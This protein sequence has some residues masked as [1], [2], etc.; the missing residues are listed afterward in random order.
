ME[1]NKALIPPTG[2][3]EV[4]EKKK[5]PLAKKPW[6][7]SI[8][9]SLISILL[10]LLLGFL[11]LVCINPS[12]APTAF[13]NMLRFGF[14][15]TSNIAAIIYLASP[16]LM[17]GLSVAFAFKAGSFNI[18]GS[19]QYIC[20]GVFALVAAELWGMPWYVCLLLALVGG[21]VCG[22]IPGFLKARFN[23]NEV[24]SAIML[25][26]I[27]QCIFY[28]ICNSSSALITDAKTTKVSNV[29]PS[30][31]LP[32]W[33][34]NNFDKNMT[35]GIFIAIIFAVFCW[36]IMNKTTLG[37]EIKACGMNKD[38]AK[39][40]GIAEKKNIVVAFTIAGALAGLG[41]GL[42]IL[43]PAEA[44]SGFAVVYNSLCS[45][46]FDGISVALLAS[47][48]PI[49]CI[50]SA[51]FIKYITYSGTGLGSQFSH[52]IPDIIVGVIVYF[53]SFVSFIKIM[54]DRISSQK[55][56]SA[57]V[58]AAETARVAAFVTPAG[59]EAISEEKEENE[60]EEMKEEEFINSV[61]SSPVIVKKTSAAV[62]EKDKQE[63]EE[64]ADD[65]LSITS[66]PYSRKL[67]GYNP[68]NV[69]NTD[70]AELKRKGEDTIKVPASDKGK[71]AK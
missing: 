60:K 9:S 7:Q 3:Q 1:Q 58:K 41:G 59:S 6:F 15:G 47:N 29:N 61:A 64:K 69:S 28:M 56:R 54:I 38:A 20:G 55:S 13:W 67:D 21:A 51:I 11:I 34:L 25:N 66:S 26:W 62:S 36:I 27:S 40:A 22:F 16:I 43:M 30:A 63:D 18:G 46:G 12:A 32:A 23:V 52:K 31:V 71:E 8:A 4:S 70:V 53:A 5:T 14:G 39:Y 44:N 33:G 57:S 37:F 49:G 68:D 19:G 35:I 48:N 50:F 65:S 2:A 10:G 42:Y 45:E 17:T 24:L